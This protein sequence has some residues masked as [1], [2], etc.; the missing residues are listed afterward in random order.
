MAE[1]LE[2][3]SKNGGQSAAYVAGSVL[4]AGLCFMGRA[5]FYGPGSVL[6]A[7]LCFMGRALFYGP[8]SVLWAGLCFMGRAL[9]YG[10]GSVLWAGLCFMGRALFYGPGSVLWL[11]ICGFS[12]GLLS[13][14]EVKKYFLLAKCSVLKNSYTHN[15]S[16]TTYFRPSYCD[17]CSGL[18]SPT[19]IAAL[20]S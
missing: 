4:W 20:A 8:G 11:T 3:I 13:E 6:W 18:V 5:L 14:T 16:E 17:H 9:F 7:G 10:P 2:G 12:Q 15:F 1:F 19:V